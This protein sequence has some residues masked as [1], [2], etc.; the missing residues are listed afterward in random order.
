[1]F[2]KGNTQQALKQQVGTG[3]ASR[4]KVYQMPKNKVKP[5]SPSDSSSLHHRGTCSQGPKNWIARLAML[6]DNLLSVGQIGLMAC[7]EN[8]QKCPEYAKTVITVQWYWVQGSIQ[9]FNNDQ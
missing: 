1:M 3:A 8:C 6:S 9:L 5:K 4:I 7:G 2:I